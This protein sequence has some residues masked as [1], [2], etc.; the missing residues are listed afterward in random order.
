MV[1]ILILFFTLVL[2]GCAG[3]EPYGKLGMAVQIDEVTDYYQQ[4]DRDWN[5]DNPYAIVAVGA[6]NEKGTYCEVYHRSN[7]KCGS[8]FNSDPET[9][10]N[11]L[12]CGVET[13]FRW[14]RRDTWTLDK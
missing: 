8:G 4:T 2:S 10:Y 9:Y 1:V 14:L 3:F 6:R 5:C 11:E 7:W 12:G 13:D